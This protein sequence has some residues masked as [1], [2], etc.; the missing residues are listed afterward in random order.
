MDKALANKDFSPKDMRKSSN[1]CSAIAICAAR[2]VCAASFFDESLW[3]SVRCSR[4]TR[5]RGVETPLEAPRSPISEAGWHA[6]MSS[7]LAGKGACARCFSGFPTSGLGRRPR[8][9]GA[10]EGQHRTRINFYSTGL[11]YRGCDH[12]GI[13]GR[14]RQAAGH[15]RAARPCGRGD[16]RACPGPGLEHVQRRLRRM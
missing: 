10:T 15:E 6:R 12:Q 13:T 1:F 2:P 3:L 5:E 7:R 4:D 11:R 14:I 9:K 8:I 16:H